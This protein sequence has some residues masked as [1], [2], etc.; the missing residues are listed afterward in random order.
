[1]RESVVGN[2]GQPL[3]HGSREVEIEGDVCNESLDTETGDMWIHEREGDAV[4][5]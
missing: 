4:S 1:M 2:M 3:Y 5:E